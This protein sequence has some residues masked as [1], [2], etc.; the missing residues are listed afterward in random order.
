MRMRFS[1]QTGEASTSSSSFP[2]YFI[3][4]PGPA[5]PISEQMTS[6]LAATETNLAPQRKDWEPLDLTPYI[7]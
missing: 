7:R 1:F 2:S 3:A 5:S 4:T 6:P